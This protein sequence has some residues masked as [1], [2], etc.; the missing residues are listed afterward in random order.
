[1]ALSGPFVRPLC[2]A[3]SKL[4]LALLAAQHQPCLTPSPPPPAPPRVTL[5][6]KE[7]AVELADHVRLNRLIKQYSQFITFPI[8]LYSPKK[9]PKQVGARGHCSPLYM[10]AYRHPHG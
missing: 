4:V 7:D 2:Q 1:M 10:C 5:F 9:E 3:S 8:K 6:L